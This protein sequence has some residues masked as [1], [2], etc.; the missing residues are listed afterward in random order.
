[1]WEITN[2]GEGVMNKRHVFYVGLVLLAALV[3]FGAPLTASAG[4]HPDVTLKNA[5]GTA[6]GGAI[7]YS[8]KQTCGGCHFD[9]ATGLYSTVTESFCQSDATKKSCTTAGNCPDYESLDTTTVNK[10]QGFL[11]SNGTVSYMNYDVKVPKHGAS[12]G[13]HSTLGRNEGLVDA[14]TTAWGAPKTISGPGMW[15]RY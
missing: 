6:A 4:V 10:R 9:C 2:K 1:M 13:K 12:I 5:A 14:Q 15:G 3:L 7:P 8:P 11:L